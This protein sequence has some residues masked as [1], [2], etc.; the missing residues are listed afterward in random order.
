MKIIT[1]IFSQILVYRSEDEER[2]FNFSH[3]FRK[4]ILFLCSFIDHVFTNSI[5]VRTQKWIFLKAGREHATTP[6]PIL[7]GLGTKRAP[8]R[9]GN[10]IE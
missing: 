9:F 2:I 5:S 4:F 1:Y 3:L 7:R 6:G 8:E 10:S